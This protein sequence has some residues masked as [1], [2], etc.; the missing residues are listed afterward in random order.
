MA[1]KVQIL[2]FT[3][4]GMVVGIIEVLSLHHYYDPD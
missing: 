3:V 1:G 4:P 2:A